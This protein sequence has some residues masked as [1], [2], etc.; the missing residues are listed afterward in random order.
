MNRHIILISNPGNSQDS[1][2]IQSTEVAIN[3]WK[4]FF[5]S[6]IGGY[7][8]D[9]EIT[10]FGENNTLDSEKLK[11]MLSVVLDTHQCDYSIIVF[12]G[13]GGC[14]VDGK[15]A[16][17]L[18][19]PTKLYPNLFPVEKLIGNVNTRR[20]LILD[21]CRS[22]IPITSQKLFEQKQYS[23]INLIDGNNCRKY[24]DSLVMESQP[25]TEI[26]YSTSLHYK[27]YATQNGSAYSET[28]SN[29]VNQ[30]TL[31]W[32]KLALMDK[33]GQF[34]Y[35]MYELQKDLISELVKMN[36]QIPDYKIEGKMNSSFPF[37]AMHLPKTRIL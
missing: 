25:H 10:R 23:E 33:C 35:S 18:P 2:Y 6:P 17:Q 16:I 14:T 7:W 32:K 11:R 29:I 19:L 34:A 3:K 37:V 31:L 5:K 22:L 12:C 4:E 1:N 28:M 8:Q 21:A 27:A 24:Y 26:L 30:K 13:H 20:T 36:I 9:E 15:D